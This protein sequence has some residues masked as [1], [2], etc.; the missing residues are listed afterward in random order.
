MKIKLGNIKS[1]KNSSDFSKY[2]E[3]NL[4]GNEIW[5]FK[6]INNKVFYSIKNL[7]YFLE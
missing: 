7:F 2:S 1:I 3:R 6:V 5:N 4:N